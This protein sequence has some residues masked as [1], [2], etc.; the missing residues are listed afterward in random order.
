LASGFASS[1]VIQSAH[2]DYGDTLRDLAAE[3]PCSE[4]RLF[5]VLE[6]IHLTIEQAARLLRNYDAHASVLRRY[7]LRAAAIMPEEA[8]PLV[9]ENVRNEYGNGDYSKNHQD[10]L[11]DL[12]W[13]SGVSRRTFFDVKVNSEIKAFIKAA[14][15]YYC[16][17]KGLHSADLLNPAIVA[18]AITAT[19]ILAVK[20]F[21]VM[22][23][24]FASLGLA[25]HHWFHHVTIEQEHQD[26]S[27]ALAKY[28]QER[29][30]AAKSVE[31]GLK[32]VLDANIHLYDG[33]LAALT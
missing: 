24:A 3:H 33:L 30:D 29:H 16:P 15:L 12:A 8:V 1:E 2:R 28:F 13:K 10:Q 21:A 19:E 32:G 18:G 5:H 6:N 31:F 9:L 27:V 26:E 17:K 4:H 14:R 20:E 25:N 23:K 11:R 22:Q 7:L